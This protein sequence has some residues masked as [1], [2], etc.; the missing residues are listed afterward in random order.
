MN[1]P[2]SAC[3]WVTASSE[4]WNLGTVVRCPCESIS[5]P[6]SGPVPV[7]IVPAASISAVTAASRPDSNRRS[8]RTAGTPLA[9]A[10]CVPG[11]VPRW[12][13]AFSR[14]TVRACSTTADVKMIAAESRKWTET[15]AGLSLVSTT[16]PPITACAQTPRGSTAASQTRSLRPSSPAA[17]CRLCHTKKAM[18]VSPAIATSGKVQQPVAELNPRV[19]Q[20]LP[21]AVRGER[22]RLRAGRPVRAAE[23]G[24]GEPNCRAGRDDHRVRDHRGQCP[25]VQ[26]PH[27]RPEHLVD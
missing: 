24:R 5:V 26:R 14:A 12:F 9:A 6:A 4:K 2:M 17:F 1:Q 18:N 20:R 10:R 19:Q 11:P 7:T 8:I 3:S 22:A 15:S 27:C 23:T 16:M 21:V 13:S 25:A